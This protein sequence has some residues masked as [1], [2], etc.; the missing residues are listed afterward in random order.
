M[1]SL[2]SGQKPREKGG[3]LDVAHPTF[4][5]GI[6]VFCRRLQEQLNNANRRWREPR[7]QL[8]GRRPNYIYVRRRRP[9]VRTRHIRVPRLRR[10]HRNLRAPSRLQPTALVQQR[11]HPH[12]RRLR[13]QHDARMHDAGAW[14][15]DHVHRSWHRRGHVARK[16]TP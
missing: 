9:Y 7:R 14:A 13:H 4:D 5:H 16:N 3:D 2:R 6:R 1:K 15:H 12:A 10:Q 8:D 11:V